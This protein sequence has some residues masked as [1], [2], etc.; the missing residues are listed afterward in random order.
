MN[1]PH[2][3]WPSE[4]FIN[5]HSHLPDVGPVCTV[6]NLLKFSVLPVMDSENLPDYYG[7]E[8]SKYHHLEIV[9]SEELVHALD[10]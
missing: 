5:I 7:D 1:V 10:F 9:I 3:S 6:Y 8:Y 4:C 2:Y